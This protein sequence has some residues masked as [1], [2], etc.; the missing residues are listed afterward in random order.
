MQQER[1]TNWPQILK[2]LL[3]VSEDHCWVNYDAKG[4]REGS[5]EVTTDTA[6]KRG[7]AVS[8]ERWQ[9]WLYTG[10][11]AAL[12]SPQV[13]ASSLISA[14]SQKRIALIEVQKMFSGGISCCS[15]AQPGLVH[16]L[17]ARFLDG[18]SLGVV[19]YNGV[20]IQVANGFS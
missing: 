10:G 1:L 3:Q 15:K 2:L 6:A 8:A 9:S 5:V 20:Y 12:C 7:L 13:N 14:N 16:I 4:A 17:N 18:G 19:S 11:H